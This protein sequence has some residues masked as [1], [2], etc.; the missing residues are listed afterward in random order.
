MRLYLKAAINIKCL[1]YFIYPLKYN[2]NFYLYQE[3]EERL[4]SHQYDMKIHDSKLQKYVLAF[5]LSEKCLYFPKKLTE[6]QSSQNNVS[7]PETPQIILH[8]SNK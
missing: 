3:I 5:M 6:A 1:F 8:S 4:K 7:S 2:I